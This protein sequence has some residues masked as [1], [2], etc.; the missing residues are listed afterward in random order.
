MDNIDNVNIQT[1]AKTLR[2]LELLRDKS[3]RLVDVAEAMDMSKSAAYNHLSTLHEL[4]YVDKVEKEYR[5]VADQ[6][7]RVNPRSMLSLITTLHDQDGCSVSDLAQETGFAERTVERWLADFEE[8]G[9]VVSDGEE[10]H[11]GL[12][13]LEI[14]GARRR[15]IR[16]HEA[17]LKKVH[18]LANESGELVNL[19]TEENGMGVYL[20][21]A[22]GDQGPKLDVHPG[23][24]CPLNTTALGKAILA[25]LSD[26]RVDEIVETHGL[27][28]VNE[29]TITDREILDEERATIRERGYAIDDEERLNG[30]RCIAVPITNDDGEILGAVS[31]S[32][33]VSRMK[34]KRFEQ[35]IPELVQEGANLIELNINYS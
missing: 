10:Y 15:Q 22:Y 1:S 8:G 28:A 26:E 30:L 7:V 17:A 19:L 32:A 4:G 21:Q 5:N 35:T 13:F 2:I 12:R 31:I 29:N 11:V 20:H 23:F 24:R 18:E 27:P 9:Y 33:P 14:G 16:L 6:S 25:Y 3:M 34:G